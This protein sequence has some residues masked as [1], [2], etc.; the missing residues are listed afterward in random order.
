MVSLAEWAFTQLLA[1]T[2]GGG[3]CQRRARAGKNWRVLQDCERLDAAPAAARPAGAA[4]DAVDYDPAGRYLT[5]VETHCRRA[6]AELLDAMRARF[7]LEAWLDTM[8]QFFL[9]DCADYLTIFF[10]SARADLLD[11]KARVSEMG[12]CT[13]FE[14]AVRMS[15]LAANPH[16]ARV[17]LSLDAPGFHALHDVRA[18][19]PLAVLR[20][21]CQPEAGRYGRRGCRRYSRGRARP[22]AR[23]RRRWTRATRTRWSLCRCASTC[24][25]RSPSSSRPGRSSR[26]ASAS[27]TSSSARCRATA[28]RAEL[29]PVAMGP[30]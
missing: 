26:T 9:L 4:D 25:G 6:C 11:A 29:T 15:C 27:S 13:A 22:R 14:A 16:A 30:A 3:A 2:D 10:R 20:P 1:S 28:R 18:V 21:A 19:S 17:A 12:V 23:V 24:R 5:A 8:R 7:G